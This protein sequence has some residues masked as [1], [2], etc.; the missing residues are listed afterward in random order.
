M[1]FALLKRKRDLIRLKNRCELIQGSLYVIIDLLI[2]AKSITLYLKWRFLKKN[3]LFS[4]HLT[5]LWSC[6]SIDLKRQSKHSG[7][8]LDTTSP[9]FFENGRKHFP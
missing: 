7:L 4:L 1:C 5:F 3:L 6:C 8:R 9:V 2:G